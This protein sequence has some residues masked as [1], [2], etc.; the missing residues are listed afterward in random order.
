MEPHVI[1]S[2]QD[3][4]IARKALLQ[5][6]KALTRAR[7]TLDRER[8]ALPWV[9]IDKPYVFEG[10][11]G[12][13]SLPELFAGRS[14]LVVQHFMMGPGWAEGCVGC[15]F[16]ADHVDAAR[17]HFEQNDLSFAAVSRASYREIAAFRRRMG[18][19][20]AWVSSFG[21]DFNYDFQ[22]SFTPEQRAAGPVTYNYESQPDPGTDELPGI[23]VFYQDAAGEVFH[24]YSTFGRGGETLAG[25]YAYLDLTPKGRNESG[26]AGNLTDWVRHHDRYAAETAPSS[27]CG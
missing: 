8:R 4:L 24:T 14:Q 10:P 6:E 2:P 26:P 25:A 12:A 11:Q 19:R 17:Q 15:S 9:R 5:K 22:V 23:S 18:W 27:C 3:W 13:V 1:V 20:F 16:S 21:T 7:D